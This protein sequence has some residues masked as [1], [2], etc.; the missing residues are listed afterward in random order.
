MLRFR[1]IVAGVGGWHLFDDIVLFYWTL[2]SASATC[3]QV[4][5]ASLRFCI[6]QRSLAW[7]FCHQDAWSFSGLFHIIDVDIFIIIVLLSAF[8]AGLL[9]LDWR[10]FLWYLDFR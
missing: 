10:A 3:I 6:Q 1:F 8:C 2:S 9:R 4:S 5:L 7:F